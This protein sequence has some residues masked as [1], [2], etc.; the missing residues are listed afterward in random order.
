MKNQITFKTMCALYQNIMYTVVWWLLLLL[1]SRNSKLRICV[2]SNPTCGVSEICD[3]GES[4][5]VIPV[6]NEA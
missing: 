3:G 1:D 4:L 5:T 2:G 6:G